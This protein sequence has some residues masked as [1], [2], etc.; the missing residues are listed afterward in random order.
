M[1]AK[2]GEGRIRIGRETNLFKEFVHKAFLHPN[3][4]FIFLLSRLLPLDTHTYTKLKKNY[5]HIY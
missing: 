2:K 4:D 3:S 5:T 1:T